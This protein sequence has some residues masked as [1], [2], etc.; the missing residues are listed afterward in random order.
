MNTECSVLVAGVSGTLGRA[1]A[2]HLRSQGYSVCGVCRGPG[3]FRVA[4]AL[5][6]A[7]PD[8]DVAFGDLTD[9]AVASRVTSQVD[10]VVFAAGSSG[11]EMSF[12]DPVAS[13]LGNGLPWLNL[14]H[15]STPGTRVIL[16]S[17]QLVYGPPRPEPFRESDELRPASPY[18]IHRML[19]EQYGRLLGPRLDLDV[20]VLRLGNVFGEVVDIELPKTHGVVPRLV[21]DLVVSGTAHLYGGGAQ[22]IDLLRA[23]DLARAVAAVLGSPTQIGGFSIFNVCGERLTV[24]RVAEILRDALGRGSITSE[25]WDPS[26]AQAVARDVRSNDTAFRARY[27]WKPGGD[28]TSDLRAF[29]KEWRVADD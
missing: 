2:L 19:L 21:R 25:P 11:V 23:E 26:I 29:G 27:G 12:G 28:L 17:S 4:E 10:S 15:A 16:L 6:A 20:V 1:V 14:L 22:S 7:L 3:E 9:L 24:R 18:A 8:V 13:L 5:E